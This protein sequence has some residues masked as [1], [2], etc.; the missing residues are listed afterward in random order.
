MTELCFTN[1]NHDVDKP[2]YRLISQQF[3]RGQRETLFVIMDS[4][5]NTLMRQTAFDVANNNNILS[6]CSLNDI[7]IIIAAATEDE[8]QIKK[9][10]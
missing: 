10:S 4:E 7:K 8:L 5:Q 9:A 1:Q 2:R 3:V 6:N